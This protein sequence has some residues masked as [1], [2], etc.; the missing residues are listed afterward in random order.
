MK[1]LTTIIL[2]IVLVFF[3][4]GV[5]AGDYHCT[6]HFCNML[7][8]ATH[9]IT[10]VVKTEAKGITVVFGTITSLIA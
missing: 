3:V 7:L 9:F 8:S 2:I 4:V 1:K 5:I 10:D 6:M